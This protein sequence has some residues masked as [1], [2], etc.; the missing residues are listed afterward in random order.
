MIKTIIEKIAQKVLEIL[1]K[2]IE[3]LINADLNGDSKIG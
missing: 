1:V 2:K 3:V